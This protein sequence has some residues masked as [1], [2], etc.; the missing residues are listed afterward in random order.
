MLWAAL[1]GGLL[2]A[3]VA[4]GQPGDEEAGVCVGEYGEDIDHGVFMLVK[5]E[6]DAEGNHFDSS[7]GRQSCL[8]ECHKVP[9]VT[10]CEVILGQDNAGCYAHTS[11][12][13]AQ[14]NGANNHACWIDPACNGRAATDCALPKLVDYARQRVSLPADAAPPAGHTCLRKTC[15]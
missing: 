7:A 9:G 15:M 10:G 6:H 2:H 11:L 1:L 12:D 5:G 8:Q 13:V 14:G 3:P 4:L